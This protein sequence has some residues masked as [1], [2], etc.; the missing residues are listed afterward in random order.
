DSCRNRLLVQCDLRFIRHVV[1]LGQHLQHGRSQVRIRTEFLT[2]LLGPLGSLLVCTTENEVLES[3][4]FHASKHTATTYE[5]QLG[6]RSQTK[7]RTWPR[8]HRTCTPDPA[9]ISPMT[10]WPGSSPTTSSPPEVCASARSS[11]SS[12][13]TESSAVR[14][15]RTQSRFRLVPPDTYPA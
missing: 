11:R 6:T 8:P 13:L 5:I 1:C 10:G 7:S 12:S 4:G 15:G 14:W 9:T 3:H 2:D